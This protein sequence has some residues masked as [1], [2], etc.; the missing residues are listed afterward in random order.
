MSGPQV[1]ASEIERF[2]ARAH[3]CV[4]LQVELARA[5][6]DPFDISALARSK[7]FD[8]TGRDLECYIEAQL[9]AR[10]DEVQKR[11]RTDAFAHAKPPVPRGSRRRPGVRRHAAA[12]PLDRGAVLD[13]D[14]VVAAGL[15]PYDALVAHLRRAVAE[16]FDDALP[17]AALVRLDDDECHARVR[18]AD[19]SLAAD[20]ALPDRV[21]RFAQSLGCPLAQTRYYGPFVRYN[22]PAAPGYF[23]NVQVRY[24]SRHESAGAGAALLNAHRDTWFGAPFH[25]LNVWGPLY[26]YPRGSGLVLLPGLFGRP[27]RNNTAGYDVWRAQ[28]GLAIGPMCLEDIDL[29]ER[30]DVDIDVGEWAVFSANHFHGTGANPGPA[31][32]ISMEL[33]LVCEE[34]RPRAARNVDFHGVGEAEG[35]RSFP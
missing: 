4:E 23:S 1:L 9:E 14:I 6:N 30:L 25:Q 3:G 12:A 7:G 28:L 8:F 35:F 22:R 13:G 11:A 27:L 20:P 17:A 26:R 29:D 2:V 32:R 18:R 24:T 21:G 15:E 34:D 19:A 31:A 5:G 10:L 33:R 16:A